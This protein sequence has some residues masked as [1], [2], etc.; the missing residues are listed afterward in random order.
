MAAR[1]WERRSRDELPRR[2]QLPDVV[3][4]QESSRAQHVIE[5]HAQ[6]WM[7]PK[8]SRR[9]RV[10]PSIEEGSTVW[11]RV[12]WN[13]WGLVLSGG[14]HPVVMW[15]DGYKFTHAQ[16][17]LTTV[18]PH[19]L[20]SFSGLQFAGAGCVLAFVAFCAMALQ[21]CWWG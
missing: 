6:H 10:P 18:R 7:A 9:L 14:E 2:V 12:E 4:G 11:H 20:A 1:E 19:L 8:W 15:C 5:G 21:P 3:P 17:E 13:G 16:A